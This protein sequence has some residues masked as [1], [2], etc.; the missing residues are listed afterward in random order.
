M[1]STPGRHDQ[2]DAAHRSGDD[3][4]PAAVDVDTSW[5]TPNWD[6]IDF[7]AELSDLGSQVTYL[8]VQDAATRAAGLR[9]IEGWLRA[10]GALLLARAEELDGGSARPGA[11][12]GMTRA[13]RQHRE[14]VIYTEYLQMGLSEEKIADQHGLSVNTINRTLTSLDV[15]DYRGRNYRRDRKAYE[16][17]A[18]VS[19]LA[20]RAGAGVGAVTMRR[21]LDAAGTPF[22]PED[23]IP[24]LSRG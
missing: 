9:T 5:M 2:H 10:F 19:D 15:G 22:R 8:D 17:G 13:E 6:S 23:Q 24:E 1:T 12:K 4:G 11:R 3:D 14:R 18:T 16:A 21:G 20:A 7:C